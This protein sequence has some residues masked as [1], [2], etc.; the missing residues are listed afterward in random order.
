MG[1]CLNCGM[2]LSNKNN[3]LLTHATALINPQ[4]ISL[5]HKM[6]TPKR[7]MLPDSVYTTFLK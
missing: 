5:S 2:L 6:S 1:G 3:K 7:Y 4:R